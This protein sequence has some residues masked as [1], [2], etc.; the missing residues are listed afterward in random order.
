MFMSGLVKTTEDLENEIALLK[1]QLD[2]ARE[3][4]DAIRSGS[5]DALVVNQ[6]SET[7]IYT[8]KGADQTYRVFIEKMKEGAVTLDKDCVILYSNSRFA[9]MVNMPLEKVIGRHFSEFI[10][11]KYKD[12]FTE[13][14]KQGWEG[15]T[16]GEI[17]ILDKDEKP[18]PFLLSLTVLQ[19]DG[20]LALSV[21]LTDL[22]EQIKIQNR[23]RLQNELLEEAEMLAKIGSWELDLATNKVVRSNELY[24]IFDKDPIRDRTDSPDFEMFH[25]D[26]REK[27]RSAIDIAV[28]TLQPF[29]IS[30]KVITKNNSEKFLLLRGRVIHKNG[31][32]KRIIGSAQD[33]T[34]IKRIEK[35]LQ[36]KNEQ[37]MSARNITEMLNK[38]LEATVQERTKELLLSKE[39]FRF[40]ADNIPQVVWQANSKGEIQFFNKYWLEYTGLTLK[41]SKG[42]GWKQVIHPD[43]YEENMKVWKH[44]IE[45]GEPFIFEHR[46]KRK[47]GVYRWH[48][49]RAH[50]MKGRAGE[51]E[52]WI[53]TN[54]DIH[55]QKVAMEK[56]DEFIG[57]AS[58]E[59]KTPLTTAKAYI[60]L[61]ER[62]L[63]SDLNRKYVMK[64]SDH[65]A[66]LN[67]LISDLLDVSK[68]QAGKLKLNIK[69][70]KLDE[71]IHETVEGMQH[72]VNN[73][74]IEVKGDSE[75]TIT[76]DKERIEQVLINFISN[77]V[78]YSP[79]SNKV[80]VNVK[81]LG[82]QAEVS[83]TDYGIGIPKD[84]LKNLF[85]KFYRVEEAAFKFQGL[86]IG[87]YISAEIIKRHK[88][89]VHV[90]SEEGKGSTFTF[91]LPLKEINF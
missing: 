28:K 26:H 1:D 64:A 48:L 75:I 84:K 87:L 2:E 66:K 34:E 8:L 76:G 57:I 67:M 13:L 11:Q 29:E 91:K 25:P 58:H 49:G 46:F 16:K 47:D 39:H 19:L 52:M 6:E 68:I 79:N 21:I 85:Q 50:A 9:A 18:I 65:I 40:L 60:Q 63:K 44:S 45:T 36:E 71:M 30:A 15:D 81:D 83:V 69:D 61:L 78:K 5:V 7:K 35:E 70:F 88:G 38:E 33:V 55:D 72:S 3:I 54:G 17:S 23:L 43:D 80:L 32:P 27:V 56:K 51:I 24:R 73:H 22:T 59:L 90:E 20:A 74:K 82:E 62:N 41:E 10:P 86:G 89:S 77:A 12:Q 42:W 37:L 53:G 31:I 14:F 4:I